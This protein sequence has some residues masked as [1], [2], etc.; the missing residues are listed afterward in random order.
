MN[1]ELTRDEALL[2]AK[3]TASL[4]EKQQQKK[5]KSEKGERDEEILLGAVNGFSL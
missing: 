3:K 2:I 5:I 4:K 1:P